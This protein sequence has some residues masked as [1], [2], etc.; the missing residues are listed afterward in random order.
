VIVDVDELQ[1][2]ER[3]MVPHD[4]SQDSYARLEKRGW[5]CIVIG[6]I[7][8]K[9]EEDGGLR[10]HNIRRGLFTSLIQRSILYPPSW[11]PC[12]RTRSSYATYYFPPL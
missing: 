2:D 6:W 12:V 7:W 11:S 9:V 4:L 3:G 1:V 10:L 5:S 8:L